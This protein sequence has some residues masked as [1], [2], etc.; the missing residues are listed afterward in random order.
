MTTNNSGNTANQTQIQLQSGQTTEISV[1]A[2]QTLAVA[3]HAAIQSTSSGPNGSLVV[4]FSNGATLVIKNFADVAV[5]QPSPVLHLSNGHDIALATLQPGTVPV[6]TASAHNAEEIVIAKPA[7]HQEVVVKLD[8]AHEYKFGFALGDA[9]SVVN[10]DGQ[11]VV[12]FKNGGVLLIP[13]Y[14]TD[15]HAA[16]AGHLHLKSGAELS[17]VVPT[18]DTNDLA[19]AAQKLA[20][21]EPAAGGPGG[22][23]PSGFGFQSTFAPD[24]LNSINPIGPIGQTELQYQA[25]DHLPNVVPGAPLTPIVTNV[26]AA[27]PWVYEDGSVALAID[28][29]PGNANEK[30]TLTVTGFD[31]SWKVDTTASGGTYDAATHTWTIT[32]ATGASFHGGPT[33]SPPHDSD[34][35]MNGLVVTEHVTNVSTGQTATATAPFDVFTDAVADLPN[36]AASAG[37]AVEDTPV[38]LTITTSPSD[39]DGSEQITKIIVSGVPADA[40]LNHGT[41]QSNGDYFLTPAQ[42]AGLT[43]TPASHFTGNIPLTITT[44]VDEVNLSGK[45]LTTANNE[46]HNSTTL[47]VNFQDTIGAPTLS[48]ANVWVKEDGKV[49]AGYEGQLKID[50]VL[51]ANHGPNDHL[52]VTV[53]GFQPGWTVTNLAGGTFDNATHTWSIT[54]APGQEFHGGPTVLPPH[55]SDADLT[56][57]VV[58]ATATDG[59]VSASANVSESVFTDAVIDGPSITAANTS[60]NEGTPIALSINVSAG[61]DTLDGSEVLSPVTITGVPL[62]AHLSAGTQTSPG[63]W[64]VSAAQLAGLTLTPSAHFTG[65]IHLTASVTDTEQNLSGL[66]QDFTDNSATVS[67]NLTVSVNDTVGAP[68]VTATNVWVK[69]DGEVKAGYPGTLAIDAHLNNPGPNDHL[70]VT[71]SGFQPGWTITNLAGGTFDNATHTWSITLPN[72]AEFHGGPTVLPPH[73]SDADLTGLTVTATATDGTV[74]SSASTTTS[75]FTDAVID[76]PSLTASNASGNEGTP[77]ALDIH[78][79][80]GGD[81]LDGSEV[82]SPVTITGVPLD[83]HLSAG[84]QTSPGVWS[85]TSAQL[86]GLTLTPGAHFSGDIHLTASVTDTEQNLSGLEQDFTDNSATATAN[87]TVTVNDIV[88]AP[89]VTATDVWVKEDG[90]VQAGYPGTLHID[91]VLNA[92]HGPNDHLV[93]TVGGFQPGWTITNL[94]GGT[95]DNATHTWSITL[96]PGAEF[97]GGPTVLPPPDSDADLTGLSVTAIATDGTVSASATTTTNVFT[98]AVI[99][100]PSV[101]ATNVTGSDNGPIDLSINVGRGGDNTDGSEQMIDPATGLVTANYVIISGVPAGASLNHGIFDAASGNWKLTAADLTG[102]KITPVLGSST[103]FDLTVKVTEKEVN[104]SGQEQDLTDNTA[105][106]TATLHVTVNDDT[107]Q[108]TP[109]SS[110][111]IVD[112]TNLAATGST[113]VTGAVTPNYFSDA[114]GAVTATNAASFAASGS[115]LGGHLTSDGQPVTVALSGNTYTGTANGATVFTLVV[116][117]NG[118][119]TFT[120]KGTLDHADASNAN[121]VINLAFGVKAT[122]SD[123]DS[124]NGVVTVQVLDDAP[125]AVA[126]HGSWVVA[127]GGATG[128]VLANDTLSQD[129]YDSVSSVTFNGTAHPVA[130]AHLGTQI[131]GLNGTLTIGSD[132]DYTYTPNANA[133]KFVGAATTLTDDFIYTLKDGDGD[134]STAHLTITGQPPCLIVGTNVGDSGGTPDNYQV[135]GGHGTITGGASDDILIGD[136]GGASSV[137]QTKNYN[138]ELVL[139][140]SGSMGS[141]SDHSSKYYLLVQA[142]DH[143]LA[144]LHNYTGGTVNINITPFDTT[145]HAS[146]SF[147]IT[148]GGTGYTDALNFLQHMGGGGT[149]NYESALQTADTWLA[150]HGATSGTDTF[151]YFITDGQPNH[152][153]NPDGSVGSSSG[154]VNQQAAVAMSQIDGTADGTNEI[155]FT[156]SHSTAVIGVGINANGSLST[157]DLANISKI[158]S[159]GHAINVTDPST[160]DNVLQAAS[161]LNKLAAVGAD[162]IVGGD[163]NDI[164]FGD[165]V[166]TDVLAAA[167]GLHTNPGAGWDV[168]T[169]LESGSSGWTRTDTINYIM[170]HT[171]EL[172]AESHDSSGAGRTGGN[173]TLEGGAGNDIIFGQEGD[174]Y[175]DGGTGNNT[176][177]GGSGADTFHIGH[178]PGQGVDTIKDFSVAQG[179]HLD[180]GDILQGF[181]PL[182]SALHNFVNVV[183]SGGNTTVQVD[184]TGHGAF[185]NVAVLEG[186]TIDINTLASHLITVA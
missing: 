167:H 45:E 148:G 77:I 174:D 156:Q 142:V 75:V 80:A 28:A 38:A 1:V 69:E 176:L 27:S 136:T 129:R 173:D 49:Q 83:A 93:V 114:P 65:D 131:V 149:T 56:G 118:S 67:T 140:V 85:L 17:F 70:V 150:T 102:L 123:G 108:L 152:F 161:P 5:M 81:T 121:D 141:L 168:F 165:S 36:I 2:G 3:G 171:T 82:L 183:N 138:I 179:D 63:V 166:N 9:S 112:E 105:T 19:D 145:A 127:G 35:D 90:K 134:T 170:S 31:P 117:P 87:L 76:G 144:D 177:Y 7:A 59:A 132:G 47:N 103:A 158:D 100:G 18:Q 157:T 104:L 124:V 146:G 119:Y 96:A 84:T 34:A 147:T 74:S 6:Q 182:T 110:A 91:A 58:T 172:A 33:V 180:I 8:H 68:T 22:A 23:A 50:A 15:A 26:S 52:V 111:R 29:V 12:S 21:V 159:S 86:A 46:N 139:D 109:D 40:H 16:D 162:H 137:A 73:D 41:L 95:F 122:D 143:L 79:S 126:D 13:N 78:V 115:V 151:T 169:Q 43:L 135:G 30:I 89:T 160:L 99:D 61:G 4:H 185:Q 153:V 10:K 178:A 48:A 42:L 51:D 163:G 11:L 88:G 20:Q 175:I 155:A 101:S 97:H 72:G 37:P 164:I 94:A 24:P 106:A 107:P 14:G 32:L 66:E 125:I 120:L 57:L 44:I 55:D 154:S 71:V 92:D 60:G 133:L 184:P 128:N 186:V 130:F 62:D 116:Q 98:D 54:L 39:V 181:D 113:A 25:P 64:T 53:T